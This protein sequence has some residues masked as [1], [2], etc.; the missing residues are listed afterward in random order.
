[1]MSRN[2]GLYSSLKNRRLGIRL[3]LYLLFLF[4]NLALAQSHSRET[5]FGLGGSVS[6]VG[7]AGI[8]F[9]VDH[10]LKERASI[11][12]GLSHTFFYRG[13]MR[14]NLSL[15]LLTHLSR[16][17]NGVLYMGMRLGSSY[18]WS[19]GGA[20]E[21]DIFGLTR[22]KE[23]SFHPSVQVLL[24]ARYHW[25]RFGFYIEG[26]LGSPYLIS[27]GLSVDFGRKKRTTDAM[28]PVVRKNVIKL[29]L[30]SLALIP[31][32][33]YERHLFEN[34]TIEVGGSFKPQK[35]FIQAGDFAAD[36]RLEESDSLSRVIKAFV[37]SRFY[38]RP[39]RSVVPKGLYIGAIATHINR[40]TL[41]SV[42]DLAPVPDPRDFSYTKA[43]TFWGGGVTIG[44]QHI[45][46]K[47]FVVDVYGGKLFGLTK[48]KPLRY[49]DSRVTELD[50]VDYFGG[51]ILGVNTNANEFVLR[52]N[53]GYHF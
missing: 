3:A 11:G 30:A 31:S 45:F 8:N 43:S 33:S 50:F 14:D 40:Q 35:S 2:S 38:L 16:T 5:V 7:G 12:L 32:A 9:M 15:R 1:M 46:T 34:Y 24:G 25:N 28:L 48:A 13:M 44:Y 51:H 37:H 42:K 41:V 18:W 39:H 29:H 22:I 27:A 53:I 10:T 17:E 23:G 26:G 36:S 21:F 19:N 52:V 4:S 6:G 20:T 49:T 47:R